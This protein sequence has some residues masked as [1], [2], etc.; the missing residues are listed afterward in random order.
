MLVFVIHQVHRLS[1]LINKQLAKTKGIIPKIEIPFVK[2]N[3]K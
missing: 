3:E 2:S 1:Q